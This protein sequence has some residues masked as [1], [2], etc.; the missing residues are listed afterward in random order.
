M[1]L[2]FRG[3]GLP[4]VDMLGAKLGNSGAGANAVLEFVK[5]FESGN[6][7]AKANST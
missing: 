1:R 4:G 6:F 2:D 5:L 7:P 3:S